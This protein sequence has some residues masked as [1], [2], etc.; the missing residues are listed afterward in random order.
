MSYHTIVD[1][2][3]EY[4]I[5]LRE[6]KFLYTKLTELL[7]SPY[8][9]LSIIYDRW[10]SWFNYEGIVVYFGFLLAILLLHLTITFIIFLLFQYI[11]FSETDFALWSPDC[12]FQELWHHQL[13]KTTYTMTCGS[14]KH[15][16][17][18]LWVTLKWT[19]VLNTIVRNM[20]NDTLKVYKKERFG[21]QKGKLENNFKLVTPK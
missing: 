12:L 18:E 13:Q 20:I 8:S 1:K 16:F 9:R 19:L 17:R 21:G 2:A 5:Y 14:W 3:K 15:G 4:I 6:D 7:S 11:D 10:F